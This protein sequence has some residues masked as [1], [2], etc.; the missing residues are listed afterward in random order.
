M[1]IVALICLPVSIVMNGQ[2]P[3]MCDCVFILDASKSGTCHCL[4]RREKPC[5]R[6]LCFQCAD[7]HCCFNCFRFLVAGVRGGG[8]GGGGGSGRLK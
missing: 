2:L 3:C 4:R 1:H 7:S 5:F 6:F 8:G